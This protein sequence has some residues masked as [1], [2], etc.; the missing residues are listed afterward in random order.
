MI[1]DRVTD[2]GRLK[3]QGISDDV[4]RVHADALHDALTEAVVTKQDLR[5]TETRLDRR[6]DKLDLV[7]QR[8]VSSGIKGLAAL[9]TFIA[10]V[11]V[12]G[13]TLAKSF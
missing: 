7:E 3:R 10:A 1:F 2:M 13:V 11:A 4:A 12:A 6:I 8:L 9:A 5:D